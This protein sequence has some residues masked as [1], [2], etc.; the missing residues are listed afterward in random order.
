MQLLYVLFIYLNFPQNTQI[1]RSILVRIAF[2]IFVLFV[3]EKRIKK[4]NH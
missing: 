1:R 3:F 4:A 2:M